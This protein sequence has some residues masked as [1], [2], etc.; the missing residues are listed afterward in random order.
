MV[1]S[2]GLPDRPFVLVGQQSLVDPSRAPDGQHTAWA[3]THVPNGYRGS[4]LAQIE[5]QMER[6]A[7]GFSDLVL[8]RHV[9]GTHA[10]EEHNANYK[11]GDIGAGLTS[12]RQL[13]ARPRFGPTPYRT[14]LPGVYL[15]SAATPPGPGVH[16]M[17]GFH[18]AR[19][20][21]RDHFGR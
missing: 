10:F 4:V 11:G 6:Y 19:L 17:A 20:A 14:G 3:Y 16:G 13:I 21:L 18:A 15:A 9:M 12:M 7:P 8:G 2:G 5:S 1:V